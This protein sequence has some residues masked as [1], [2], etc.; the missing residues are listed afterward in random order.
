MVLG[1]AALL[2][3]LHLCDV[4]GMQ[5]QRIFAEAP[6]RHLLENGAILP[7]SLLFGYGLCKK[8][9]RTRSHS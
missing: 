1:R 2:P 5:R 3:R 6:S 7:A 9:R 8:V 4:P